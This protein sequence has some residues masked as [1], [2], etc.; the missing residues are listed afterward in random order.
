MYM[1][2]CKGQVHP[3]KSHLLQKS[4]VLEYI[5]PDFKHAFCHLYAL[6]ASENSHDVFFLKA[7]LSLVNLSL[8]SGAPPHWGY[9]PLSTSSE[10][11]GLGQPRCGF[12][13][14]YS[15]DIA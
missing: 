4:L 7:F 6:G 5:P 14:L 10:Y 15:V 3:L 11:P 9:S 1:L 8:Y 2:E 12:T 13:E